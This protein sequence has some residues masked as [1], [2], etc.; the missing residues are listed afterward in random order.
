M[1]NIPYFRVGL[2]AEVLR[3][4]NVRTGVLSVNT[5]TDADIITLK[6]VVTET[7]LGAGFHWGDFMIDAEI[8]PEF[9]LDGPYFLTGNDN[10]LSWKISLLYTL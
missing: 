7:Y 5:V 1:Y 10:D 9:L 4:L 6:G 8:D 2:D 3:W